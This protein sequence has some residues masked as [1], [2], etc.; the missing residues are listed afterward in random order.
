MLAAAVA[1]VALSAVAV[2]AAVKAAVKLAA[3]AEVVAGNDKKWLPFGSHF[4]LPF[5]SPLKP[6]GGVVLLEA[7]QKPASIPSFTDYARI[8]RTQHIPPAHG[9]RVH[10]LDLRPP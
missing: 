9:L 3:A 8:V 1:A 7:K 5:L 4:L 2:K 10:G 6:A